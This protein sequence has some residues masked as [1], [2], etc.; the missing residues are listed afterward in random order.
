MGRICRLGLTRMLKVKRTERNIQRE[1][2]IMF[3]I[4]VM[5][6]F[7]AGEVS[8]LRKTNGYSNVRTLAGKSLIK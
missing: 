8:S 7:D 6:L 3:V 1:R 2:E 5:D 4:A